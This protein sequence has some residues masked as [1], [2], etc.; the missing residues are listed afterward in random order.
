MSV[1]GVNDKKRLRLNQKV[2]ECKP[3][4]LGVING[5]RQIGPGTWQR[6][7]ASKSQMAV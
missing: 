7:L 4:L 3:L 6:L 1:G 5:A 2:D